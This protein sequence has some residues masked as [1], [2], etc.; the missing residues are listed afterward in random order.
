MLSAMLAENPESSI[1]KASSGLAE[2]KGAYRF[3][4]NESVTTDSLLKPLQNHVVELCRG[5]EYVLSIGDT[6][7]LSFPT[8][9]ATRG[10]GPVNDKSF[11][12]GMLCHNTLIVS[13][14]GV[15]LGFTDIFVWSRDEEKKNSSRQ[16]KQLPIED[17][18]SFKWIRSKQ[19]TREAFRTL[20]EENWP[21]IIFVDDREGDI[22]EAFAEVVGKPKEQLVIRCRGDRRISEPETSAYN[23]LENVEKLG[24]LTVNVPRDRGGHPER[25]AQVDLRTVSVTL[26]PDKYIYPNRNPLGLTLLWVYEPNP[27]EGVT[28]IDWKLWTTLPATTLAEGRFIMET[29]AK[30]W[31]IER[32]KRQ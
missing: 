31:L 7:T 19:K 20:P 24:H 25:V 18:E 10:L 15:P 28:R 23:A 16:R 8:L 9:K 27:P 32:N 14:Q 30:R 22:H 12:R 4:E 3:L 2:A 29:Y 17:K 6:T 26:N 11:S 5:E 13:S 1:P 21:T